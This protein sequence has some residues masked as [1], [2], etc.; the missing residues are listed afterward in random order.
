MAP[1]RGRS[2]PV[3]KSSKQNW[4]GNADG[5]RQPKPTLR[6]RH[7][8]L[9]YHFRERQ[10]QN[11]RPPLTWLSAPGE[12]GIAELPELLKHKNDGA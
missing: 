1:K 12:E 9:D 4:L 6:T 11:L 3:F 10:N 8:L 5:A 2:R 7:P